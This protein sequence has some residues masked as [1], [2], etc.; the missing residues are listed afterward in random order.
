MTDA[1]RI[2]QQANRIDQLTRERDSLLDL[3]VQPWTREGDGK[4][5]WKIYLSWWD[6]ARTRDEG[7]AMVWE[8]A[9]RVKKP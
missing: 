8:A 1:D 7:V 2:E 6:T 5:L 4:K 9:S 3:I